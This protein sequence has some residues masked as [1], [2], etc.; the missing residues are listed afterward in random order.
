M[1]TTLTER[2]INEAEEAINKEI[3]RRT[4][5]NANSIHSTYKIEKINSLA[6]VSDQL[7]NIHIELICAF[8]KEGSL[9]IEFEPAK[10]DVES[11]ISRTS[12]LSKTEHSETDFDFDQFDDEPAND[13]D[14]NFDDFRAVETEDPF[15]ELDDDKDNSA[16]PETKYAKEERKRSDTFYVVS[17]SIAIALA[18]W[19]GGAA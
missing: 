2:D 4:I 18:Y 8:E 13:E 7:K 19:L 9:G 15:A 17:V 14:L 11:L 6:K 16:P 5:S 1:S 12:K 10:N 3:L